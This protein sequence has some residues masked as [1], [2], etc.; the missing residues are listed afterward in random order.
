MAGTATKSKNTITLRGSSE[1][2]AEFFYY[3]IN[4]LLYQRGIYP[5]ET[6]ARCDMYKLPLLTTTDEHLKA[7]LSTVMDQLKEWLNQKIVQ[8][9]V[10]TISSEETDQVM[11]RWQFDIECDKTMTHD[12]KPREKSQAEI[13][14]GIQ[15]VIKQITASVTFLP[16]L[17]TACKFN[18]LIYTDKDLN[19][20]EKWE[21]SG[22]SLIDNSEEVRLRSFTTS[23]HKV[24]AMVSY[25]LM[26]GI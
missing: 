19:T 5:A 17:E 4:N 12:S 6:F 14:K 15:A 3:G 16:L 10:V 25:K 8:K 24:N 13:H 11:E 22:P 7:Y 18:L 23:I 9:V 2:V 26:D 1:I 21:E 20:P